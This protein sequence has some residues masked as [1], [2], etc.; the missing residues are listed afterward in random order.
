MKKIKLAIAVLFTCLLN[1]GISVN[2]ENVPGT[3]EGGGG[4]MDFI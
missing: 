1:I 3:F 2:A 4:T